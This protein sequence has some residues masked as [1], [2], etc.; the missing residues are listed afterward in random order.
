MIVEIMSVAFK[1]WKSVCDQLGRGGQ[2]VILRKGGIAEG[3]EGF[4]W[5]HKQFY[6]FPTAYH[7][8]RE[9]L[10][11]SL[12]EGDAAFEKR[13]DGKIEIR[14]LAKIVFSAD[15]D[16]L[17]FAKQLADFHVWKDEVIEQRFDYSENK[18]IRLALLRVYCLPEPWI[19]EDRPAFGG[20]RSWLDL[21]N[22]NEEQAAQMEPVLSDDEFSKQKNQLES[23]LQDARVSITEF[24]R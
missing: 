9:Q 1:E 3:K 13:E 16:D 8:H 2:T 12:P 18:G 20:C 17:A 5:K 7:N 19:L 6:L 21:P 11:V 14:L 10:K 22:G 23:L 24:D 4:L 15:I